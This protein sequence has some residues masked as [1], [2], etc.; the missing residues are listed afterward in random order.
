MP[1]IIPWGVFF[2]IASP[3]WFMVWMIDRKE[4]SEVRK[5]QEE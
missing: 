3:L 1:E 4:L 5:D 2:L